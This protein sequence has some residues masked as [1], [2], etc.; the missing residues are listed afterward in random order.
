MITDDFY[1]VLTTSSYYSPEFLHSNYLYSFVYQ[2]LKKLF[3][4]ED[5]QISAKLV[6]SLKSYC[7]R[8]LE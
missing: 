8:I 7:F 5:I 2:Y 1:T 6:D 3:E 4:Q